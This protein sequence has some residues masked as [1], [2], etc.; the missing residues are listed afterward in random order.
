MLEKC[1]SFDSR[2][3]KKKKKNRFKNVYVR[4]EQLEGPAADYVSVFG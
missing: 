1:Q 2:G 3:K 4:K